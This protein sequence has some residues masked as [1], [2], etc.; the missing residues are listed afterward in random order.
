M[1]AE[2]HNV[3]FSFFDYMQQCNYAVVHRHVS[4]AADQ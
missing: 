1:I 4:D 3:C 2:K